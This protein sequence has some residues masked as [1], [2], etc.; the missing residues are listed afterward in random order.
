VLPAQTWLLGLVVQVGLLISTAGPDK[1]AFDVCAARL[2][3]AE[4]FERLF[5]V[6]ENAPVESPLLGALKSRLAVSGTPPQARWADRAAGILEREAKAQT[7]PD[8][9]N[10]ELAFG[11]HGYVDGLLLLAAIEGEA[12]RHPLSDGYW[13]MLTRMADALAAQASA[14]NRGVPIFMAHGRFDDVIPMARARQSRAL[15]ESLGYAV[16]W[17]EY[18]MPHSVCGE[19]IADIAAWLLKLLAP[20]P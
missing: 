15:L 16:D 4:A 19:E 9:R 8:G 13:R 7:F 1:R 10:R 2:G 5:T 18:P 3:T 11:Y 6:I 20:S 17:R 12:T 14:G